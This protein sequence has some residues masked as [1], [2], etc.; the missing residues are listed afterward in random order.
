MAR[1]R[2]ALQ[3]L[4]FRGDADDA[5]EMFP[6][7]NH[8]H[9]NDDDDDNDS[10][11]AE[12]EA[13]DT[14]LSLIGKFLDNHWTSPARGHTNQRSKFVEKTEKK[15]VTKLKKST[16][17]ALHEKW[18]LHAGHAPPTTTSRQMPG[19][20]RVI[21]STDA[22]LT[23][24]LDELIS[25]VQSTLARVIEGEKDEADAHPS[26]QLPSGKAPVA[27]GVEPKF[28]GYVSKEL[29][30]IRDIYGDE[31]GRHHR[32]SSGGSGGGGGSH[33]SV[34]A[35]TGAGFALLAKGNTRAKAG[36]VD[37]SIADDLHPRLLLMSSK[38]PLSSLLLDAARVDVAVVS[39]EADAVSLSILLRRIGRVLRG[40]IARSTEDGIHLGFFLFFS[41][42]VV[43]SFF[44]SFFF[45]ANFKDV[46]L[47][48]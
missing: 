44:S 21:G 10:T 14:D 37:A 36:G 47:N 16:R 20:Q 1:N 3:I 26:E 43:A 38:V 4:S 12:T 9:F 2:E 33:S 11:A 29:M 24:D 42:F 27:L 46:A 40:R 30:T 15:V 8:A 7:Y 25:N 22:Q 13:E 5:L 45:L 31:G 32:S 35:G 17:K 39:Y 34:G 19:A 6:E 41:D 28:L 23:A 48:I 18:P